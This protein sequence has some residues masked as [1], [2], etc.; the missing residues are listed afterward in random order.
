[1][2]MILL[3]GDRS[4]P[5]VV[6]M[7]PGRSNVLAPLFELAHYS[8]ISPLGPIQRTSSVLTQR[9]SEEVVLGFPDL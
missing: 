2:S 4:D 7:G 6:E 8:G 9:V 3:G 5:V 1:M